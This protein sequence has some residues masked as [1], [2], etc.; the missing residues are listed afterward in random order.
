LSTHSL[1]YL[2]P[3]VL[4]IG[5][6]SFF[7]P[8]GAVVSGDSVEVSAIPSRDEVEEDEVFEVGIYIDNVTDLQA[9]EIFLKYDND[10]VQ[11]DSVQGGD[12]VSA[13]KVDSKLM[14]VTDWISFPGGELGKAT[15]G[16]QIKF[17][18]YVKPTST[19]NSVSGS[20]YLA[21]VRFKAIGTPGSSSD[22]SIQS[23]YDQSILADSQG[24]EIPISTED[25]SITIYEE[26]EES[27]TPPP[28]TTK[29][30]S[31]S[32]GG[33]GSK[34]TPPATTT[35]PPITSPGNSIPPPATT[36]PPPPGSTTPPPAA[37]P[38]NQ[39]PAPSPADTPEPP[40]KIAAAPQITAVQTVAHDNRVLSSGTARVKVKAPSEVPLKSKFSFMV[41]ISDAEE[42]DSY[43]LDIVYNPDVIQVTDVLD[44]SVGSA[45][46][47]VMDWDFDPP[48]SEGTIKVIGGVE[49]NSP[50]SG[51]GYL[52]KVEGQVIGF[53]D[54]KSEL[55]LDNIEIQDSA[56]SQILR[57]SVV[58]GSVRVVNKTNLF[59]D[60]KFLIIIEAI[61]VIIVSLVLC[62]FLIWRK[63][64][65]VTAEVTSSPSSRQDNAG[66]PD[67]RSYWQ[68][69]VSHTEDPEKLI[70][71][72][73]NRVSDLSSKRTPKQ[74]E[75]TDKDLK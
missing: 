72:M 31:S 60:S 52:C 25:G 58:N 40:P 15:T 44:G 30:S 45:S 39:T 12:G 8:A 36:T 49:G 64:K 70:E 20:G 6:L 50:A 71:I 69:R 24:L 55:R 75:N 18:G 10:V 13:G 32:S 2:L 57:V 3:I 16:D 59:S 63:R 11:V 14:P 29:S 28:T 38:L 33:S 27:E 73:K 46:M 53:L 66:R 23:D 68:K 9:W 67:T 47:E 4:I 65:P 51:S 21:V 7:I 37:A 1:K 54:D 61:G 62:Y 42:F 41:D 26:P 48:S 43:S 35:T 19:E 74:D 5:L 34:T 56:E 22:F 17:I